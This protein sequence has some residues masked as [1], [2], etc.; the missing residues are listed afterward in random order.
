MK[1]LIIGGI[2]SGKSRLAESLA[3]ASGKQVVLIATATADDDEMRH[4]IAKHRES[5]PV[6]WQVVEEPIALAGAV[7]KHS[8]LENIVIIDCLTLWL[9]NLLLRDSGNGL[10]D[11][12]SDLLDA[13]ISVVGE[14]VMVSNETSMG[15]IPM[16]ELTRSYCDEAGV[17]HQQIAACCDNV[18]LTVAGLPLLLKGALGNA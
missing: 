14:I 8:T 13:L 11:E 17:L 1:T 5:R 7:K 16:G 2:K 18:A 9:T 4:R 12:V 15:I 10:R 6:A 3:T